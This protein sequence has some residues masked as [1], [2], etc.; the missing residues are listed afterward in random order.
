MYRSLNAFFVNTGHNTC[1]LYLCRISEFL[2]YYL[3]YI[4]SYV[5][6]FLVGGVSLSS[7]IMYVRLAFAYT[8]T[9]I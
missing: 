5:L 6:S 3:F 4:F 2:L 8:D 1:L 9:L 7:R